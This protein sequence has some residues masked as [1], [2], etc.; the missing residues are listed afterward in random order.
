MNAWTFLV[1]CQQIVDIFMKAN[2]LWQS[3]TLTDVNAEMHLKIL[4]MPDNPFF[5]FH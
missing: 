5:K 3:T 1:A 2:E 4:G